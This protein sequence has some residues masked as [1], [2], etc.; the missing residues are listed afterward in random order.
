MPWTVD[1]PI[2]VL[3]VL[4]GHFASSAREDW[5]LDMRHKSLVSSRQTFSPDPLICVLLLSLPTNTSSLDVTYECN[6]CSLSEVHALRVTAFAPARKELLGRTA[7][8][9]VMMPPAEEKKTLRKF[10]LCFRF[11]P[12]ERSSCGRPNAAI[13]HLS[14]HLFTLY[15]QLNIYAT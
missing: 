1:G 5:N 13:S 12:L 6:E 4:G 8:S 10:R 7:R 3:E 15:I 11:S 2:A 14:K 9:K